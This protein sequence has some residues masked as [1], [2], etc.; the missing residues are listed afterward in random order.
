MGQYTAPPAA[1]RVLTK[2]IAVW[3]LIRYIYCMWTYLQRWQV[4]NCLYHFQMKRGGVRWAQ[5]HDLI[6]W[7]GGSDLRTQLRDTFL[8][9]ARAHL[10][11]FFFGVKNHNDFFIKIRNIIN[12]CEDRD[13]NW[14]IREPKGKDGISDYLNLTARGR[15]VYAYS[16]LVGLL[17]ENYY[18]KYG[19]TSFVIWLLAT[20]FNIVIQPK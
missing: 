6:A 8:S 3:S 1:G 12:E 7:I 9:S 16:H 14:I 13:V 2:I 15:A 19:I 18:I 10:S 5:E 11:Y 17:L 20:H 4:I